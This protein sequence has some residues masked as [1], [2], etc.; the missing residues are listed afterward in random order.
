M[1]KDAIFIMTSNLASDEIASYGLKLRRESEELA[2]AH[3][4]GKIINEQET[5]LLIDLTLKF[6]FLFI[7][8]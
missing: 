3:Y 4:S 8:Q 1:C 2:K 5:G 7:L 6:L